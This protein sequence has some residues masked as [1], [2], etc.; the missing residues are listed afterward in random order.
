MPLSGGV[1]AKTTDIYQLAHQSVRV[2]AD[3]FFAIKG[4]LSVSD[5]A[6]LHSVFDSLNA[7]LSR[8]DR[9]LRPSV[10]PKFNVGRPTASTLRSGTGGHSASLA[11]SWCGYIPRGAFE[12]YAWGVIIAGGVTATLALFASGTIFGLPAGAVLGAA[13]IWLGVSGSYMLWFVD[14]YMPVWSVYVCVF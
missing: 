11:A 13:G 14:T 6:R 10:Q 3:G 9:S 12:A 7:E 4:G 1:A 5:S 8:V 2:T